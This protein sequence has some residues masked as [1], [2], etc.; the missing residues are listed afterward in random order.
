[1]NT[2]SSIRPCDAPPAPRR[3]DS[4]LATRPSLRPP[5]GFTLFELTIVLAIVVIVSAI[6]LPRYWSSIARYRVDIAARRLAADISLA[7]SHARTSGQFHNIQFTRG[8]LTYTLPEETS[9]TESPTGYVVNL[10]ASPF[11]VSVLSFALSDGGKTITFD[12]FG[13][14][15]QSATIQLGAIGHSRT[16]TLNQ[17]SGAVNV[18]TP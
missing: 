8:S 1:V 13:Q 18:A 15:A 11:N 6:A 9:F 17:A 2:R 10:D 14:A 5:R 3:A 16:I 4:A 12:G 7:Q